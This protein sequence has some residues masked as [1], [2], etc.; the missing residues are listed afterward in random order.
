MSPLLSSSRPPPSPPPLG[1]SVPC[2]RPSRGASFPESSSS[3]ELLCPCSRQNSEFPP[4][5]T[6]Y[7][8]RKWTRRCL[9]AWDCS[10]LVTLGGT[11]TRSEPRF[12]HLRNG[13]LSGIVSSGRGRTC[14][15]IVVSA[16]PVWQVPVSVCD[17]IDRGVAH[18][19]CSICNSDYR[20][21]RSLP[22]LPRPATRGRSLPRA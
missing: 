16:A 4:R 7:L 10:P 22:T 1:P 6:P 12:P 8:C 18:R 2:P 17:T 21:E 15:R 11:P 3:E 19:G 9:R 5:H 13:N 14:E 20:H